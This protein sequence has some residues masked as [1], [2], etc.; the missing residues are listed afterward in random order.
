MYCHAGLCRF[1]QRFAFVAYVVGNTAVK[2]LVGAFLVE[3]AQ[4]VGNSLLGLAH[5]LVG[6]PVDIFLLEAAP[7]ALHLHVVGP[8]ALAVQRR[9]IVAKALLA[10]VKKV[11]AWLLFDIIPFANEWDIPLIRDRK[12]HQCLRANIRCAGSPSLIGK[13]NPFRI[14]QESVQSNQTASESISPVCFRIKLFEIG[15]EC[16]AIRSLEQAPPHSARM[17]FG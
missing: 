10:P 5:R 17:T 2:F 1:E 4:V 8:A 3:A 11:A 7:W 14:S 16:V 12:P 6:V 13:R 9:S 15:A